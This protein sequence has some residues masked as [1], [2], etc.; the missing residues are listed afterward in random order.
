MNRGSQAG[1]LAL[2]YRSRQGRLAAWEDDED[3]ALV[4]RVRED[5][6]RQLND[7]STNKKYCICVASPTLQLGLKCAYLYGALERLRRPGPLV[8][9]GVRARRAV[10]SV[11][12]D[13]LQLGNS[14]ADVA[15]RQRALGA[16]QVVQVVR[17]QTPAQEARPQRTVCNMWHR[18][19]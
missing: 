18:K 17:Q 1:L 2:R 15:D 11:D 6:R 10:V 12:E 8:K 14:C 9:R 5:L 16:S 4:A 7:Y 19:N 3:R 13:Q